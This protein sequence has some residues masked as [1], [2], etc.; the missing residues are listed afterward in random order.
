MARG[1]LKYIESFSNY[2]NGVQEAVSSNLTTPTKNRQNW[3]KMAFL[4]VLFFIFL[5]LIAENGEKED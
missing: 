4:T 2:M 5:Q 3:L 1:G